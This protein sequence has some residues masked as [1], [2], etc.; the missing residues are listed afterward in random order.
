MIQCYGI[1]NS[2]TLSFTKYLSP[3]GIKT[4]KENVGYG[5]LPLTL[6]I[7]YPFTTYESN[8]H[9]QHQSAKERTIASGSRNEH[10]CRNEIM[11]HILRGRRYAESSA[12]DLPDRQDKC[13]I[14]IG[15]T[16]EICHGFIN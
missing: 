6:A 16:C 1:S 7:N 4:A 2:L 3:L 5:I 9:R 12:S 11:G 10:N 8:L 14:L 13:L 15:L